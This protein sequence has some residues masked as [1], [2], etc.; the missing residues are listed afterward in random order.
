MNSLYVSTRIHAMSILTSLSYAPLKLLEAHMQ[1]GIGILWHKHA[2]RQK[3]G[4]QLSTQCTG[5]KNRA[6]K[7]TKITV[8]C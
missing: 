7:T 5:H 3:A 8:K 1:V 6:Q 2:H 4:L